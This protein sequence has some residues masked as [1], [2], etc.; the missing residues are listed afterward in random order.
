M[1]RALVTGGAAGIGRALV[2]ELAAS[3]HEVVL[4]DRDA[5]A[6]EALAA[7]LTER[8]RPAHFEFAD[9]TR[10]K[11]IEAL[12]ARLA[13]GP[14]LDLVVHN[15]GI[16]SVGRF[17]ESRWDEQRRVLEL[18]A[19]APMLLTVGLLAREIPA[20]AATFVFVSS[21]SFYVGYPG[22]ASYAASKDA[23]ASYAASLRSALAPRGHHVLTVFPGP[24]RTE[25][26]R[27]HSPP[28]SSEARRMP[29]EELAGRILSAVER[30]KRVL[31]PG[32]GNRLLASL[33]HCLPRI[34]EQGM[35]RAI[36]DRL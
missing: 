2:L 27:R 22:A 29:P 20:H 30:R 3:G 16:N 28:G 19:R 6:G 31:V 9:L 21:L 4:V 17:A 14:P 35:R 7:E 25:H 8:G 36:L 13:D 33:G 12:V 24:T 5:T 11:E 10:P 34:A 1:K 26:A 18:N 23:L 32:L 15:A